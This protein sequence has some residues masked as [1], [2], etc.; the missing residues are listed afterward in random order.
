MK[1]KFSGCFGAK[2]K[3]MFGGIFHRTSGGT[4][5]FELGGVRNRFFLE[6]FFL[7]EK[8][9]ENVERKA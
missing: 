7:T 1:R 2:T 6:G 5:I 3:T 4:E 8:V 9:G